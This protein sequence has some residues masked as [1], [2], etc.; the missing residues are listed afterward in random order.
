MFY[1][2]YNTLHNICTEQND[3]FDEECAIKEQEENIIPN[4]NNVINRN[5]MRDYLFNKC[6]I[7]FFTYN[8]YFFYF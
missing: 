2:F 8:L 3:H 6:L 5:S 4:N 1:T 7:K